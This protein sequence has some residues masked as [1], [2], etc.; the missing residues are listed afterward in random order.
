ML[1]SS[2]PILFLCS[3]LVPN[4]HCTAYHAT[5]AASA[6]H[7]LSSHVDI[8]AFIAAHG[9]LRVHT[10]PIRTRVYAPSVGGTAVWFC[11]CCERYHCSEADLLQHLAANGHAAAILNLVGQHG[12]QRYVNAR[13]QRVLVVENTDDEDAAVDAAVAAAQPP[14]RFI[15]Q[16][17]QRPIDQQPQQQRQIEQQQQR[18]IEAHPQQRGFNVRVHFSAPYTRCSVLVFLAAPTIG[19]FIAVLD[20][21]YQE[22]AGPAAVDWAGR[23]RTGVAVRFDLR[24]GETG[25]RVLQRTEDLEAD[26]AR[27][28]GMEAFLGDRRENGGVS[29]GAAG[30]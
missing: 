25:R 14:P 12:L 30:W 26:F 17:Q 19:A 1:P 5:A 6:A 24:G 23:F 28:T 7:I 27:I 22:I 11:A 15:E 2:A 21:E 20:H 8:A 4:P 10:L 3:P 9:R 29:T 18:P 13:C 16:Q